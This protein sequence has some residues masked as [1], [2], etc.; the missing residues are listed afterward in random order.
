MS[1]PEFL[2]NFKNNKSKKQKE[3]ITNFH[4][5]KLNKDTIRKIMFKEKKIEI[6]EK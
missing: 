5:E 3:I 1:D 4:N 2:Q 6:N